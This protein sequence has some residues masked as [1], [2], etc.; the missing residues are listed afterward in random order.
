MEGD[1]QVPLGVGV[2][3][4][5]F[6]AISCLDVKTILGCKDEMLRPILACLVSWLLKATLSFTFLIAMLGEDVLDSAIRPVP[7]L[8]G[9][10]D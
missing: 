4:V 9:R 3:P 10:A 1:V 7:R 8:P 5:V 6:R 2:D